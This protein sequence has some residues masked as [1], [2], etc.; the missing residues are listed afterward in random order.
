MNRIIEASAGTGK[1]F[2][3]IRY[4]LDLIVNRG[5]PIEQLLIATFSVKAASELRRRLREGLNACKQTSSLPPG[6]TAPSIGAN[7]SSHAVSHGAPLPRRCRTHTTLERARDDDT[8]AAGDP[9]RRDKPVSSRAARALA[10]LDRAT[11]ST[12][13]EFCYLILR[14]YA[15]EAGEP[16]TQEV[17]ESG[18]LFRP[19]FA[20]YLRAELPRRLIAAT[21]ARPEA[22]ADAARA[23]LDAGFHET[24]LGRA[25]ELYQPE[26]ARLVPDLIESD[27]LIPL[28]HAIVTDLSGEG[29]ARKTTATAGKIHAVR[30]RLRELLRTYPDPIEFATAVGGIL[31]LPMFTK[32]GP[33]RVTHHAAGLIREQVPDGEGA[34]GRLGELIERVQLHARQPL[35]G[36]ID[37]LAHLRRAWLAHH[38]QLDYREMLLRTRTALIESPALIARLRARYLVALVDEF[39]DTDLVQWDIFRYLFLDH[40]PTALNRQDAPDQ[41]QAAR[42]KRTGG[43]PPTEAAP[44][45]ERLTSATPRHLILV[46]DEKQAIYGFRGADVSTL[47][48]ATAELIARGD[49]IRDTLSH[50]R[51]SAAKLVAA[52]D[53]F[54]AESGLLE[55][56]PRIAATPDGVAGLWRGE[57]PDDDPL[58]I[59]IDHGATS[60]RV[61]RG[62]ADF[63]AREIDSL[64]AG[65]YHLA[66][67]DGRRRPL[68][69]DDI[70]VLVRGS[71][72][73][74][75][76]IAAL[77]SAGIP[78]VT[79]RPPNLLGTAEAREIALVLTA[80]A[81]PFD[82]AAVKRALLTG[83]FRFPIAES[84]RFVGLSPVDPLVRQ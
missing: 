82:A 11:I 80:I 49:A 40:V 1:T 2:Q 10:A 50:N 77:E 23:W 57:A 38:G 28:S 16:F 43:A 6:M 64:L 63:V 21:P 19:I 7:P 65:G 27:D 29:L 74:R 76:L 39:Q 51:R 47:R 22:W 71:R 53:D 44:A 35:A 62:M 52:I 58:Q 79:G 12:I 67:R 25:F 5:V 54:F 18:D 46:G 30:D 55:A 83:F 33:I 56:Y 8:A 60:A 75:P 78:Y 13:H 4:A 59:V 17:V 20:R 3:I 69:N 15:F 9:P 34:L 31:Q 72:D 37:D 42:T 48:R 24:L 68:R 36:A 41:S 32:T 26:T 84:D 73:E 14:E 81:N 61:R 70:C 45:G 66:G